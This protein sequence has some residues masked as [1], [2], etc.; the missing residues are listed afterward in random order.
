[1][2]S[3]FPFP[4]SFPA[5]SIWADYVGGDSTRM[6]IH[7][8]GMPCELYFP[9]RLRFSLVTTLHARELS[10]VLNGS[11]PN[12][13]PIPMV[14]SRFGFHFKVETAEWKVSSILIR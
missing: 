13:E 2:A 12:W 6:V 4:F 10:E 14:A 3:E 8:E 1:M 7:R 5:K 9:C 11:A